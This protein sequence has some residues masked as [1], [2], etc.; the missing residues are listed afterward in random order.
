MCRGH[1]AKF[2]QLLTFQ[3]RRLTRYDL[4]HATGLQVI[5]DPPLIGALVEGPLSTPA[6][7]LLATT[8]VSSGA[9]CWPTAGPPLAAPCMNLLGRVVSAATV[10]R[11]LR[12]GRLECEAGELCLPPVAGVRSLL[13]RAVPGVRPPAFQDQTNWTSITAHTVARYALPM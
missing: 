12:A 6:A 10:F 11:G 7:I 4:I 9:G 3:G 5:G 8:G 1:N 2:N 13:C